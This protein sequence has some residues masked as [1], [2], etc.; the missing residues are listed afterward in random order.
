MR[1]FFDKVRVVKP[2][3]VS[4]LALSLSRGRVSVSEDGKGKSA[5]STLLSENPILAVTLCIALLGGGAGATSFIN[6][7]A[8]VLSAVSELKMDVNQS[9]SSL[10]EEVIRTNA[11]LNT[12]ISVQAELKNRVERLESARDADARVIDTKI[13]NLKI[14]VGILEAK[15]SDKK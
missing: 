12:M 10:R 6:S 15:H 1:E 9:L 2:G 13:S 8:V 4:R 7:D 3:P 5:I 14:S 11:S